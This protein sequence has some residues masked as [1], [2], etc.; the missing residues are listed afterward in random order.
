MSGEKLTWASL[1]TIVLSAMVS[2]LVAWITSRLSDREKTRLATE[3]R[4]LEILIGARLKE[5]PALYALLSDIPK[6]FDLCPTVTLDPAALL[7]KF[8]EWDSQHAILMSSDT[9][10]CCSRFR[11]ALV[12]AVHKQRVPSQIDSFGD[13]QVLAQDLE[14]ALRSDLGLQG[15]KQEG[16]II[17]PEKEKGWFSVKR[18]FSE[19]RWF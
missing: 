16:G 17:V 14:H 5:Y 6:A 9:S 18:W 7:K 8:N 15:F 13:V 10:N 12:M 1:L 2:I 19:K 11:H 3:Q 4:N